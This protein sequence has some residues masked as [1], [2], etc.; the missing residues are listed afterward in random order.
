MDASLL[1]AGQQPRL[2]QIKEP[3]EK[4]EKGME[5]ESTTASAALPFT[6]GEFLDMYEETEV[7]QVEIGR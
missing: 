1:P 5:G 3:S 4:G 7:W 2:D 6:L